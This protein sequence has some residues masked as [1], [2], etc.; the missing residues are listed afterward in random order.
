MEE[1]S[2][3]YCEKLPGI[4]KNDQKEILVSME[5]DL[6]KNKTINF[7]FDYS[8][9][10]METNI[11]DEKI[12]C[13]QIEK[14]DLLKRFGVNVKTPIHSIQNEGN[15]IYGILKNEEEV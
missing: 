12:S 2:K 15:K 1:S 7:L 8:K 4:S 13:W 14:A 10:L 11:I 5:Y 3:E 9:A 6:S